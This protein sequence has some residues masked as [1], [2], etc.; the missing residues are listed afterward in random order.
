MHFIERHPEKRAPSAE[1]MRRELDA[2]LREEGEAWTATLHVPTPHLPLA[3]DVA[4]NDVPQDEAQPS[5]LKRAPG[6]RVV[7]AVAFLA[8][9]VASLVGYVALRPTAPTQQAQRLVEPPRRPRQRMLAPLSR[10]LPPPLLH[11]LC[12]SLG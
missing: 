4:H 9:V 7:G 5:T 3:L 6:R 1:V 11:P 2:L 8:L 12:R 10:W